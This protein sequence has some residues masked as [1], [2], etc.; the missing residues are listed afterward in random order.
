MTDAF[1]QVPNFGEDNFTEQ[2]FG[3]KIYNAYW[4]N[5]TSVIPEP[6]TYA[7]MATGLVGLVGL[8]RRRNSKNLA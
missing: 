1:L 3:V 5:A 7:L 6:S 4:S 8:A 2:N